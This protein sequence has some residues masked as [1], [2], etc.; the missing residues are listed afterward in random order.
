MP[1][2]VWV[3]LLLFATTA[4]GEIYNISTSQGSVMSEKTPD[5]CAIGLTPAVGNTVCGVET[6]LEATIT[7][8][9]NDNFTTVTIEVNGNQLPTTGV[10]A[11]MIEVASRTYLVLGFALLAYPSSSKSLV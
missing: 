2:I 4:N 8:I 10:R 1:G 7:L 3:L 11:N 5:S 9:I 6:E